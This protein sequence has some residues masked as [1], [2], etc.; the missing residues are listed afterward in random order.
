MKRP[1]RSVVPLL[2]PVI[3]YTVMGCTRFP[4][5][6]IESRAD[7]LCLATHTILPSD[8]P[9]IH[10]TTIDSSARLARHR[11]K[12]GWSRRFASAREVMA[13]NHRRP[14]KPR[15]RC[16][17]LHRPDRARIP[18]TET[19][20]AA[21]R[22]RLY[23]CFEVPRP[24]RCGQSRSAACRDVGSQVTGSAARLLV[25]PSG[26]CHVEI[27]GPEARLI[28]CSQARTGHGCLDAERTSWGYR[29]RRLGEVGR[30]VVGTQ[31]RRKQSAQR[32]ETGS[33]P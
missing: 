19:I 10:L 26:R 3:L 9:P 29:S 1:S 13:R 4:P 11:K 15:R 30:R 27:L 24:V 6:A 7:V 18:W 5:L 17:S 32:I 25:L 16:P 31:R 8:G 28:A 12:P 23:T 20:Y 22:L 14:G 33:L 21:P 2:L